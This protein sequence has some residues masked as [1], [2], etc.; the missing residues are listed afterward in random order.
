MKKGSD[1]GKRGEEKESEG[2][3]NR[4]REKEGKEEREGSEVKGG[5]ARAT[6]LP[7]E[8]SR[9]PWYPKD[10]LQKYWCNPYPRQG[11]PREHWRIMLFS[12]RRNAARDRWLQE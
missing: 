8:M 6:P 1:E 11:T 5:S 9:R 12:A 2:G 3:E 4:G 7:R 10:V